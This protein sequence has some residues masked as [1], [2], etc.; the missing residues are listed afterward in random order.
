MEK[1][2]KKIVTCQTLKD[3]QKKNPG[4]MEVIF[5]VFKDCDYKI[6]KQLLG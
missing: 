6:Y 2:C 1:S 5:N 3:Y 4:D